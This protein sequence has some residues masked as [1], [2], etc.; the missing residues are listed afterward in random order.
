MDALVAAKF[1]E[2]ENELITRLTAVA[3]LLGDGRQRVGNLSLRLTSYGVV[4]PLPR[5]HCRSGTP[6]WRFPPSR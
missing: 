3:H 2:P 6:H 4:E 5:A 1:S